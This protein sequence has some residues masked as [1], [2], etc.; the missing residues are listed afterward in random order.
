MNATELKVG[1]EIPTFSRQTGL[2]NW[3]RFAAVNDEFVDI[4]MDAE[5]GKAA[6]YAGAFGMGRLQFSYL[7]MVLTQWLGDKG[8]IVK[9]SVQF[10]SPNLQHMVLTAKGTI[11]A[12]REETDETFVDLDVRIEAGDGLVL[13]PGTAT[14]ALP[15][16]VRS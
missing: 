15:N 7:N 12:I 4:H 16:A 8:R 9:L 14:V 6:G 1:H 2:Q 3:N 13:S 5:A 10:R 11:T